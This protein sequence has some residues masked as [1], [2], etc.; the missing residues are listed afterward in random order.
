M[1]PSLAVP[2]SPNDDVRAPLVLSCSPGSPLVTVTDTVQLELA[3]T[4][5][6]L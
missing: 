3:A 4:V 1:S 5:P 2:L 6:P